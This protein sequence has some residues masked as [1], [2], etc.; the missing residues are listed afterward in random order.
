[1]ICEVYEASVLEAFQ[2]GL[3]GLRSFGLAAVDEEGE[4]DQL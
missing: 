2:D 4:V 3:C 1:V